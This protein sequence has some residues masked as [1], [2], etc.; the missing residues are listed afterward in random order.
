M[1]TKYWKIARGWF[2]NNHPLVQKWENERVKWDMHHW[3]KSLR[4]Y[5]PDRYN[6]WMI[7][8]LIPMTHSN[9]IRIHNMN[10]SVDTHEKWSRAQSGENNPMYGRHHTEE[11]RKKIAVAS[12][13]RLHSEEELKKMSEALKGQKNPMYGK[14]HTEEELK[15]MSESHQKEKN[16]ASKKVICKETGQVF[17]CIVEAKEWLGKGDIYKAVRSGKT[18]GVIIGSIIRRKMYFERSYNL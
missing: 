3:D 9:H 1:T 5:N 18:A 11:S 12:T 10:A 13:G 7:E 2:I 4:Y 17:C 15:K 16:P 14:H 8:D 6:M